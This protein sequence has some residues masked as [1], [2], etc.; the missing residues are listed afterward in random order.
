MTS[1]RT[2]VPLVGA[3]FR[4]PAAAIIA[5]LPAGA[6]LRIRPEPDNPHDAN[7]LAVLVLSDEIPA[8]QDDA[9]SADAVGFGY[10]AAAIR[11]QAEWHIGYIARQH[12]EQLQP[13]IVAAI[14]VATQEV[15]AEN[16]RI[17]DEDDGYVE[18][19][20]DEP[21][22]WWPAT[23]RFDAAGKPQVELDI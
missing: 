13:A 8:S 2:V 23:L 12:A 4:P 5:H 22:D 10:D 21:L 6:H 16:E 19:E 9:L 3:F 17:E 20:Y 15:E 18:P 11:A 14:A 7:A 1:R